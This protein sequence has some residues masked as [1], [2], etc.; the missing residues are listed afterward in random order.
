MLVSSDHGEGS[1]WDLFGSDDPLGSFPLTQNMEEH[2][3][4]LHTDPRNRY[5]VA[6][7][8]AGAIAVF[9]IQEYCMVAGQVS[10]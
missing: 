7:D 6:G 1:F 9:D 8:T 5:L 10:Q 4:A 2:V 3:M